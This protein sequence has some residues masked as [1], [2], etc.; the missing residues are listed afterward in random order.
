MAAHA[1]PRLPE[2]L[3]RQ[4]LCSSASGYK[5]AISS[6]VL[7]CTTTY[8]S[9]CESLHYV[10]LNLLN[11]LRASVA[12]P[13]TPASIVFPARCNAELEAILFRSTFG[14]PTLNEMLP[15]EKL[16]RCSSCCCCCVGA[17]GCR[18]RADED[19]DGGKRVAASLSM[20]KNLQRSS[21]G[22]VS[23]MSHKTM[24]TK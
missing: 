4:R 5:W 13:S 18:L 12:A 10:P 21:P 16:Y 22:R 1:S 15:T 19:M 11:K 9:Y 24:Q 2:R 20:S 8:T 14:C 23:C 17:A 7:D 6:A 3:S